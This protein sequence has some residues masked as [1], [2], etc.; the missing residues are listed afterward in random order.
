MEEIASNT[1]PTFILLDLSKAVRLCR[2]GSLYW[3]PHRSCTPWRVEVH[4][5]GEKSS[6]RSEGPLCIA[7]Y[8]DRL[9]NIKTT[10]RNRHRDNGI[11][12]D[13]LPF[14]KRGRLPSYS[15]RINFPKI[16]KLPSPYEISYKEKNAWR[17]SRCTG[18]QRRPACD[19]P[20]EWL[21]LSRVH[22]QLILQCQKKACPCDDLDL[23]EEHVSECMV[24]RAAMQNQV[25]KENEQLYINPFGV[26]QCECLMDPHHVKYEGKCYA[27]HGQGHARKVRIACSSEL[28]PDTSVLHEDDGEYFDIHPEIR[29]W[30]VVALKIEE[31]LL[32]RGSRRSRGSL[33]LFPKKDSHQEKCRDI[34][35]FEDSRIGKRRHPGLTHLPRDSTNLSSNLCFRSPGM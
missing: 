25:C 8:R 27:L 7:D 22:G 6:W 32:E 16:Y 15:P 11:I 33:I 13:G 24:Y 29:S 2:E 4:V 35:D 5:L 9:R 31:R 14:Q 20:D 17:T 1:L 19:G 23:C 12:N 28:C 30:S 10:I 3:E 21:V 18:S 34:L 26:G